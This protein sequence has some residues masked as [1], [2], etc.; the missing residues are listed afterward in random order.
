M[1]EQKNQQIKN[2]DSRQT[3]VRLI[4]ALAVI[5]ALLFGWF[6][7][8]WQLGNMM[9]EL[10][11]PTAINAESIGELA[12]DFAPRDPLSNW[13]FAA[14]RK[15]DFTPEKIAAS[16]KD[17]E[18]VVRYAPNDYRWWIE[19][20]R[21]REQAGETAAAEK[22]YLRAIE[23]A[24]S[25]TYPHWQLG[26]FYLRQGKGDEAFGELKKVAENSTVY[27]DQ[28]FSIA[29]DYYEQDT[30]KIEKIAG[31]SPSIAAALATFYA[32]KNRPEDSLRIWNTLS[33]ESKKEN[34]T[35]AKVIAQALYEKRYFRQSIEFV[36]QLEIDPN[37]KAETVQNGDFE[38]SIGEAKD[39]YFGW[40]VSSLEKID[41][42]LDSTQKHGG[43]RSLR[44]S[45]N[46]FSDPTLFNLLQYVVVNPQTQY[47]L[48]FWIRT[49]NLKSAGTPTL[50]IYN[51]ND[52]KVI[53]VSNPFPTGK[54]DWQQIKMDFTTPE[55]AEAVGIRT[56]RAFC[57]F[58]CPI[59]GTFWYDDFKLEKIK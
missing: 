41:I 50:E 2:L 43:M 19:L 9:A 51:A 40:K 55:N 53:A 10:T 26:N 5:A 3:V 56:T 59:I 54:T 32:G 7:M 14:T 18:T 29:W 47:R 24:P 45:F 20:G 4:I 52:D 8:R 44:W 37:A 34:V 17:F 36:R 39:T 23:T 42:K 33:E 1:D 12:V 27:R 49:D 11:P 22:A 21:A 16:V 38:S 30:S 58:E 46:G 25:Y 28:V 13:L 35:A 48:S 57:G 6:S 15:N 31:D